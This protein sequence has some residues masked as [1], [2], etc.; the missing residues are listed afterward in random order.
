MIRRTRGLTPEYGALLRAELAQAL[1]GLGRDAE[2]LHLAE[3]AN[4]QAR[5]AVGLA[6]W[7]G[8]LA[9]WRL[10]RPDLA[11][12]WFEAAWRATIQAPGHRSGA[13]FWAA[14]AALVTHGDS[15]QWLRRAAQDP[16]TFYGLLARRCSSPGA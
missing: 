5:G 9:A 1:F 14:R 6:P 7:I 2:A 3:A 11:R 4:L 16:R 15:T 13:A 10:G 12:T 8:W